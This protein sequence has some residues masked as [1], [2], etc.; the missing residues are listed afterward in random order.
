MDIVSIESQS[1]SQS[2]S[3]ESDNSTVNS[4]GFLIENITLPTSEI[5]PF[6]QAAQIMI[7]LQGSVEAD[8]LLA[9]AAD[10]LVFGLAGNDTIFGLEGNDLI[11]GNQGN[12]ELFGNQGN[13]RLYAGKGDD[14]IAGGKA[15]DILF[16][17]LGS[18]VLFGNLGSDELLGHGD[19]D[20]LYGGQD[21]DLG[22]GGAGDDQ[23]FGDLGDDT[24]LGDRGADTITSGSGNDLIFIGDGTGGATL[25]A[26]DVIVDFEIGS[27]VLGLLNLLKPSELSLTQGTGNLAN[28]TIIQRRDTGEFLAILQNVEANRLTMDQFQFQ[29]MDGGTPEPTPTPTPGPEPTP[30]PTPIPTPTPT[31]VPT[32]GIIEFSLANV[33]VEEDA[34]QV[35]FI[36]NR[37]GG[38]DG[39]ISVNYATQEGTA[40][41]GSDYVPVN[42]TV[43]FASGELSKTVS[44]NLIDD[45]L[46]ETDETFN[47]VLSNPTRGAALGA[48]TTT[49]TILDND[50]IQ[51]ALG[52]TTFSAQEGIPAAEITVIRQGDTTGA[53]G[54]TLTQTSGTATAPAD[55]SNGA[56]AVNFAPGETTQILQIPIVDDSLLE[57]TE[58]VTVNLTNPTGGAI[59]GPQSSG[60]LNIADNEPSS[61]LS[62]T[63][64]TYLGTAANDT[65]AAVKISPVD[66]ALVVAGNF[67]NTGE[68]RRLVNG[69]TAPLSTTGLGG[70]VRDLDI[71]REN[72]NIATVGTFGVRVLNS[73][74]AATN[75]S[76]PG[77]FDDVRSPMMAQS[78]P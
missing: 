34:G 9:T 49:A 72:G 18:D 28:D 44:V 46:V 3:L 10:D 45:T 59:L 60:I 53:V 6:V 19:N 17:D 25:V 55:Y 37:I 73:T 36:V 24:L 62:L 29:G 13:D 74:A 78:S 56:I 69:N 65:A 63:T 51:I 21:N 67:N 38:S 77:T 1:Q 16:G 47:L 35:Q 8:F 66:K 71:D 43:N 54:A 76:Q 48:A 12:D 68:I 75:W 2:L 27:D 4:S 22:A 50:T 14:T 23:L 61:N 15:N 70:E 5:D 31:P 32:P 39:A 33:S 64:A 40:T 57:S 7:P 26:A 52:Q 42:T 20:I 58:F 30:T 11:Q 41:P